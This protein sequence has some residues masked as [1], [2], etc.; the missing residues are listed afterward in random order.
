MKP[1]ACLACSAALLAVGQLPAQ[2]IWSAAGVDAN[3]TTGANW[4]DGTA[5]EDPYTGTV[6]FGDAGC[7]ATSRM[8][9]AWNLRDLQYTNVAGYVQCF[10]NLAFP[11]TADFTTRTNRGWIA[12]RCKIV[13]NVGAIPTNGLGFV[14]SP[15]VPT[16]LGRV[17]F[18]YRNVAGKTAPGATLQLQISPDAASW[19]SV[20]NMTCELRSE[21]WYWSTFATNLNDAANFYARIVCTSAE[22]QAYVDNFDITF[23][24]PAQQTT[25]LGGNRLVISNGLL[26]IGDNGTRN[27]QINHTRVVL[28]NGTLQIGAPSGASDLYVGQMDAQ[29]DAGGERRGHQLAIHGTLDSANLNNLYVGTVMYAKDSQWTEGRLDLRLATLRSGTN[30]DTLTADQ[31]HVGTATGTSTGHGRGEL[32]L[33][34]SLKHIEVGDFFGTTV[35]IGGACDIWTTGRIETRLKGSPAGLD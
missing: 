1:L 11:A 2:E 23:R 17:R 8:D 18:N 4:A 25:D 26:R 22:A 34:S 16:G 31:L 3:W 35:R 19:T 14:R 9:Q 32:L 6:W 5:P 10:D 21:T 33:P 28:T 30:A 20:A 7:G 29:F 15:Y 12:S 24:V 13:D 27:G